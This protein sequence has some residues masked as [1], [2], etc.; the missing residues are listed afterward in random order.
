MHTINA[1]RMSDKTVE[2]NI[3][4]SKNGSCRNQS[5]QGRCRRNSRLKRLGNQ[6]EGSDSNEHPAS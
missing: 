4:E 6:V 5:A 1:V 2:K 3:H